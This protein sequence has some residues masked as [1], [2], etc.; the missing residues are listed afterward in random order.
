MTIKFSGWSQKR[1]VKWLSENYPDPGT[2]LVEVKLAVHEGGA[3]FSYEMSD[4]YQTCLAELARE[5][6]M[7]R[8]LPDDDRWDILIRPAHRRRKK[9]MWFQFPPKP[10]FQ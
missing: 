9:Q 10:D 4:D 7:R 6:A 8:G 2:K 5:L 1:F 3:I